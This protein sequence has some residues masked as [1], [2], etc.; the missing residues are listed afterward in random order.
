MKELCV[1][2]GRRIGGATRSLWQGPCGA[3]SDHAAYLREG[4]APPL[5]REAAF[6]RDCGRPK[7]APTAGTGVSA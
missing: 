4:Q 2:A 7:V 6:P 5:Q 1:A 3:K